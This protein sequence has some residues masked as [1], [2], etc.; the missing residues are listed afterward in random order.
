MKVPVLLLRSPLQRALQTVVPSLP[1]WSGGSWEIKWQECALPSA[2]VQRRIPAL[3]GSSTTLF[4]PCIACGHSLVKLRQYGTMSSTESGGQASTGDGGRNN[5]P[6]EL[7]VPENPS[8]ETEDPKPKVFGS[9]T[10]P[11]EVGLASPPI[12]SAIQIK[13]KPALKKREYGSKYTKNNFITA[14]RA[15]NDFCLKPSDLQHLRKILRRSPHDES[16]GFS[17]FVRSDVEAKALEVWGS[18]D[19]LQMEKN[20]RKEI[21]EEYHEKVFKTRKLLKEYKEFF[22]EAKPRSRTTGRFMKGPGRVVAVALFINGLNFVFK[23]L[24]W[25]HTGSASMFSECIHSLA[26]TLN[27]AIL[28]L[29]IY[30]S[31]KNPDPDHPYGFSNMRYITS[32]ISGVGIFMM[33]AG[34]S[35]YHGVVAMLHPH[36]VDSLPW[37]FC[38]LGGSLVSEGATLLVAIRQ[39]RKGARAKDMTFFEYVVRS[40]DPSTNVVLLEDAAAVL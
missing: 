17:V 2:I 3:H 27:Q 13:V 9:A 21:Q 4:R 38:I 36:T 40:G 25:W 29:G 37:V 34:L 30:H 7:N 16:E 24:A 28:A 12:K 11:L 33:G 10:L 8:S 35:W 5:S 19:A 22:G 20:R 14:V 32:L 6:P 31:I 1:S 15:F 18:Y 23:F 39:V 26:D